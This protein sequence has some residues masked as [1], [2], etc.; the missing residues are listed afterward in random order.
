MNEMM[1]EF[2]QEAELVWND[3]SWSV[4]QQGN[5]LLVHRHTADHVLDVAVLYIDGLGWNQDE[6]QR[7][8]VCALYGL[9]G[10]LTMANRAAEY[11]DL[12]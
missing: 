10:D 5:D 2:G 6:R 8:L 11:A 4:V 9:T 7:R 12:S 3:G 1:I